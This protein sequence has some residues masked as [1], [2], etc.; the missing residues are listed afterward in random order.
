MRRLNDRPGPMG[1]GWM[2]SDCCPSFQ[3][4]PTLPDS[5][6]DSVKTGESIK[7]KRGNCIKNVKS[8]FEIESGLGPAEIPSAHR[9]LIS[10][11]AAIWLVDL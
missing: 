9:L 3:H 1:A 7:G 10:A 6:C 5:I 8:I 2:P 11:A 4:S